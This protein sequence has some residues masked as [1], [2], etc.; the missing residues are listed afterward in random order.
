MAP[1]SSWVGRLDKVC[2]VACKHCGKDILLKWRYVEE[3]PPL[4]AM[5]C[6]HC[7]RMDLYHWNEVSGP[8]LPPLDPASKLI[9][10]LL[11]GALLGV[12]S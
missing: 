5:T 3:V 2:S 11:L 4:F 8:K 9:G 1:L 7:G 6:P 12:L 10:W